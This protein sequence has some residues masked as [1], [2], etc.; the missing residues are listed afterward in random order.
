M[1]LANTHYDIKKSIRS[2][3]E[4]LTYLDLDSVPEPISAPIF[5]KPCL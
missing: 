3:P 4:Y 2:W 5:K 1:V